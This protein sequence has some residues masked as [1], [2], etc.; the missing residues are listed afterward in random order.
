AGSPSKSWVNQYGTSTLP[1][2]AMYRPQ[3]G[4]E[5]FHQT[6]DLSSWAEAGALPA[7]TRPMASANRR[8][9]NDMRGF[10]LDAAA[11]IRAQAGILL[12]H[13]Q[14]GSRNPSERKVSTRV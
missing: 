2:S 10:P 14:A 5:A 9:L 12:P 4:S 13:V 6:V 1:W 11:I 7:R 8:R 3:P